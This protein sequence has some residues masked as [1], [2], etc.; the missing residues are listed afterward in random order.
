M[1]VC[2]GDVLAPEHISLR[3]RAHAETVAPSPA[4]PS[5]DDR[6]VIVIPK[7]GLS[8]NDAERQLLESTLRLA[9]FNQSLAARMLGVSRP[10]IVRM[11]QKHGFR[12]RRD[13]VA[14]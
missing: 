3:S 7:T 10:T 2:D 13:L 12:T 1:I 11:M 4:Q 9:K 8:L 6:D 5:V 14:D